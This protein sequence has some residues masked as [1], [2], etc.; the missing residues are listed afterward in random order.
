M[1][2]AFRY[3]PVGFTTPAPLMGTDFV[4]KC[5]LVRSRKPVIRFLYIGPYLCS[6][7]LQTPPHGDALALRGVHKKA[8]PGIAE[9]GSLV[10]ELAFA[11]RRVRLPCE[12]LEGNGGP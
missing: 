7:L 8:R 11:P 1:Q 3:V 2:F 6:T 9:A 10:T 5:R 12:F 4:V